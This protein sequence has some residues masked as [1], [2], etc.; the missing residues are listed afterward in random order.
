[1]I[2]RIDPDRDASDSQFAVGQLVRHRRYG[3]RGVIVAYD[4]RCAAADD[5]YSSNQT[6]P[7]RDQAWYHVFVHESVHVT[8][9]AQTSLQ[10]DTES[11][12]IMHPLVP[13]YFD[14]LVGGRYKRNGRAWEG[15]S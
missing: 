6:Q 3:Y 9:A 8:Y 7:N 10:A 2:Q 5:W 1:M 11:A 4:P 12:P 14:G 15:A 13:M